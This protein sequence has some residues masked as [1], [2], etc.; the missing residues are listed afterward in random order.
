MP[1]HV[2]LL[3]QQPDRPLS[4]D[5]YRQLGGYEALATA[6][7]KLKPEEVTKM[8]V[9]SGLKR[10]GRGRFPHRQEMELYRQGPSPLHRPQHR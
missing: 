6:L 2:L 5:E 3:N 4:L 10:P 9:E 1:E 8:V 7:G